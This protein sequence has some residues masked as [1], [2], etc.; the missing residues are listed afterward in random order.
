MYEQIILSSIINGFLHCVG[1]HESDVGKLME[2]RIK[3]GIEVARARSKVELQVQHVRYVH[4]PV[5]ALPFWIQT[6][7]FHA[8][9]SMK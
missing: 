8:A 1:G 9:P 5:T 4:I 6:L 7:Q 3:I 2:K